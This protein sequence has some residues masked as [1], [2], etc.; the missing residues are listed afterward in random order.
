MAPG[1]PDRITNCAVYPYDGELLVELTGVDD[2]GVIV[3]VSY[4]F[5]VPAGGSAVEPR[6]PIE[7][8]HVPHVRDGLSE[9]GYDWDGQSEGKP[10]ETG[11]ES[12]G[13]SEL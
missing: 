6:G 4:Q 7:P 12:N 9:N 5:E 2:E 8:E 11:I 3:V 1:E 10:S 13:Q